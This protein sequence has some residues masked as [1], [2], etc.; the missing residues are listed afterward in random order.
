MLVVY[1]I[2]S[3]RTDIFQINIINEL[4]VENN[5]NGGCEWKRWAHDNSWQLANKNTNWEK[6]GNN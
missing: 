3:H 6:K 2:V 1:C 4:T 5:E